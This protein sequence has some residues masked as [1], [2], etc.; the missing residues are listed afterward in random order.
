MLQRQ[1][2][3][4]LQAKCIAAICFSLV[5]VPLGLIRTTVGEE[6]D[7][8]QLKFFEAKIRPV[9][10]R[11]CYS[12]HSTKVGQVKG[13]LWLD[14]K[15]GTLM[16]GD[17]GA[18]VVPGD[19]DESL[20]WNAINHIDFDMPPRKKLPDDVLADFAKWIEMGAP[21]PR[22]EQVVK[23]NSTITEKDIQEG[24]NFWSFRAPQDNYDP[25]VQNSD[26]PQSKIDRFILEKL[27][28]NALQPAPDADLHTMVRRLSFDLIGL[29]PTLEQLQWIEKK[30]AEGA[31]IETILPLIVDSLLERPEFGERWGRHWLDVAR[32]AESS[33]R[34]VNLTYPHAWRYRDYVIDS[35]NADKPYNRFIEEQIAG[36]LLPVKDDKQ[37]AEN[38]VATG[39]LAVG[40]KSLAEQNGRQFR[41]DLVDEQIDVSTQVILGVSVACARCHDHK[42][43]PIPQA[44][45]YA[46]AGIFQN[47]TTHYGTVSTQQNRR[48]SNLLIL[49]IEDLSWF[50]KNVSLENLDEL[51][52]Q[53]A[54]K[55]QEFAEVIRERRTAAMSG[56]A[57]GRDAQAALV[58]ILRLTTEIGVLE[59]SVDRYD[60]TGKPYSYVMGVQSVD[61]PL[62]AQL[63]VRGEFDKPAGEI[64]RGLPQVLVNKQPGIKRDS[65]GRL[66]LARWMADRENPLTA[67]VMVNRIWLHLFGNGIVRTPENFG[68]TGLPPTHPELLDH[69]AVQFMENDWSVKKLIR[70]IVTSRVYRSSSQFNAAHFQ[71]DPENKFLWRVEPRR[72]DAEVIRDAMLF[73]SNE[74]EPKRPRASLVAEVG[75]AIV[76]DGLLV[77]TG[78]PNNEKLSNMVGPN[79]GFGGGNALRDRMMQGGQVLPT[80]VNIDRPDRYR[81]VY[82]PIIRDSLP[83]ALDVFDFAESSMVIGQRESSN[84]PD[85][86]LYFL[87]NLFVLEQSDAFARRVMQDA[88]GLTAQLQLAFRLAYGRDA[89]STELAAT[90]KFYRDFNPAPNRF[91]NDRELNKM[92]ACCQAIMAAAE[93]RFV[94]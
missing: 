22:V 35:F 59:A 28:Q 32:F 85:Q 3:V 36:D 65:T 60:E 21:D 24:K 51:K 43:D 87:N 73:V 74:L 2:F 25:V 86:G 17:S 18:A 12:C 30:S 42:F 88:T 79:P 6:L 81:S 68:A 66:E 15:A 23:I 52:D 58:K 37:W 1:T 14:T 90:E 9:L 41:L 54:Q 39:F 53:L 72:L 91:R 26:W 64:P 29:P 5:V 89:T 7:Q 94:N 78:A 70:E 56:S 16:G 4:S 80:I 33:G 45:Y 34:E 61:R 71:I 11:E 27:E 92:S 62:N 93:F 31:T 44:D 8:E 20:L 40:P 67:R 57:E 38:L 69:L 83:R 10:V 82:L 84:T 48:A 77:T 19:L 46:L 63:L 55:R 13:G 49:P 75:P 50:D 76:R 47:T